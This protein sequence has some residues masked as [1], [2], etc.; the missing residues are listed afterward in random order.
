MWYLPQQVRNICHFRFIISMK[1]KFHSF[2]SRMKLYTSLKNHIL[3]NHVRKFEQMCEECGRVFVTKSALAKHVRNNHRNGSRLPCPQCPAMLKNNDC[4]R[5]HISNVHN[6]TPTQCPHC[7]KVS[8]SHAAL[9]MHIRTMHNFK[10]HKC[11][12]CDQECRSAVAL[13]EHTATHTG[14]YLYKCVYCQRRFKSHSNMYI[15]LRQS[16]PIEWAVD[17]KTSPKNLKDYWQKFQNADSAWMK[18]SL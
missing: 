14:E 5:S 11:Q 9:K 8:P 10:V 2:N 13:I 1:W 7:P 15:H 3:Q 6:A 16:H 12:I 18:N 17:R 4:L